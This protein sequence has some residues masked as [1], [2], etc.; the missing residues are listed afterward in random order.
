MTLG[1]P[2]SCEAVARIGA[3]Q[4]KKNSA[5]VAGAT[6]VLPAVSCAFLMNSCG[7]GRGF[8]VASCRFRLLYAWKTQGNLLPRAYAGYLT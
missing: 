1:V 5:K 3:G 2:A 6:L 4:L 7:N 8:K